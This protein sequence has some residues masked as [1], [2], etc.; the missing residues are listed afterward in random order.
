MTSQGAT[1]LFVVSTGIR[2]RRGGLAGKQVEKT[3]I[4]VV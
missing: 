4:V 3:T 1:F 2:H